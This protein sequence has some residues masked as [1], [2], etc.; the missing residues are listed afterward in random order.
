MVGLSGAVERAW[1]GKYGLLAGIGRGGGLCDAE[2]GFPR[3]EVGGLVASDLDV[4]AGEESRDPFRGFP[5]VTG[6][7]E[8]SD[9]ELGGGEGLAVGVVEE[10]HSFASLAE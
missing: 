6:D 8:A 4:L 9:L 5:D 2:A 10:G 7:L 3:G 1:T